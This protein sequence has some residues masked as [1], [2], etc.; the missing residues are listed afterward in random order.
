MP[1]RNNRVYCV[2]H[3]DD[4][5]SIVKDSNEEHFHIFLMAKIDKNGADSGI[6]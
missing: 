6:I 5:M 4:E 2:N 3:P 1:K